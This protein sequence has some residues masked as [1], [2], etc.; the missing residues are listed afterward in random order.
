MRH[1]ITKE[2]QKLTTG[3]SSHDFFNY[4]RKGTLQMEQHTLD[5]NAGKLLS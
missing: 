2:H 3:L 4:N 5:T 1:P